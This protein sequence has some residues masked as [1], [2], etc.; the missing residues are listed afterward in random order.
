MT[1]VALIGLGVQGRAVLA[2]LTMAGVSVVAWYDPAII[3]D[4]PG[5]A[6][7]LDAA[8]QAPG[9]DLVFIATPPSQH[10]EGVAA[11][12]RA[13]RT[14]VC[15]KPL[16]A[17]VTTAR[18]MARTV[19]DAGVMAGV[20]FY[21]ATASAGIGLRR[22]ADAGKLGAVQRLTLVARFARWPRPWQADAGAWLS[23]P[24]QGG[25]VREVTS[26]FVYLAESIAGPATV[27]SVEIARGE[28]GLERRLNATLDHQ[29]VLF[30]IDA[31]IGGEADER[32]QFTVQGDAATAAIVD[33]DTLIGLP[34]PAPAEAGI[35]PAIDSLLAGRADSLPTFVSAARVVAI[36]EQLLNGPDR[37]SGS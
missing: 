5:R 6:A 31:A 12:A 9:V 8:C 29:G 22:G 27:R 32:V 3:D 1:G 14:I 19:A 37:G 11:A 7:S 24:D 36:V 4:R 28:D 13:G 15:E 2:E 16:S 18:R 35:V 20:N 17:D 25:F 21:L 34:Y 33:W 10:A 23:S 30:T 26:H